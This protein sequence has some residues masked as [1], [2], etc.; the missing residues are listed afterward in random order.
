MSL[1]CSK[2]GQTGLKS[3]NELSDHRKSVHEHQFE[4]TQFGLPTEVLDRLNERRDQSQ[5]L[6]L[7]GAIDV[8]GKHGA[9][10]ID[11]NDD[12]LEVVVNCL[13]TENLAT[14]KF[15]KSPTSAKSGRFYDF[16]IQL[17][18]QTDIRPDIKDRVVQALKT[19]ELDLVVED[20]WEQLEEE[21]LNQ[22]VVENAHNVEQHQAQD[23]INEHSVRDIVSDNTEGSYA[24]LVTQIRRALREEFESY[25]NDRVNIAMPSAQLQNEQVGSVESQKGDP[26]PSVSHQGLKTDND[27]LRL[28]LNNVIREKND[29][30]RTLE[31]TRGEIERIKNWDDSSVLVGDMAQEFFPK[32]ELIRDSENLLASKRFPDR[33]ALLGVLN[34][35]NSEKKLN[36]AKP[37]KGRSV[38]WNEVH[39]TTGLR[40]DGRLYFRKERATI[41]VL[42]STKDNQKNDIT[43]IL[44]RF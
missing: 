4:F 21:D 40:D 10:F 37:C 28:E 5:K 2:C 39:F 19:S 12:E 18:P 41:K 32:L 16:M 43:N 38:G 42:I 29:I 6:S 15:S 35:L 14:N 23:T 7:F 8:A 9:L 33:S 36:D 24:D 34:R 1:S 25:V 27:A 20:Y 30:Q 22:R 26:E 31:R 13:V 3:Q 44:P 11:C 17:R